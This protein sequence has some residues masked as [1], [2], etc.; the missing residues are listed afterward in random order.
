MLD[1]AAVGILTW[2]HPTK[3]S[4]SVRAERSHQIRWAQQQLLKKWISHVCGRCSDV[5]RRWM[6]E[7][8]L[9]PCVRPYLHLPSRIKSQEQ[10]QNHCIEHSLKWK[11]RCH[12]LLCHYESK[13][14]FVANCRNRRKD[15]LWEKVHLSAAY[16]SKTSASLCPNTFCMFVIRVYRIFMDVQGIEEYTFYS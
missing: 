4:L 10:R 3:A 16:I 12:K 14:E 5:Y 8:R 9:W 6:C 1:L 2:K 15:I 13:I 7:S 11:C